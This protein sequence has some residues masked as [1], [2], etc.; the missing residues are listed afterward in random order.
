MRPPKKLIRKPPPGKQLRHLP[1]KS[2]G[3]AAAG[4]PRAAAGWP[5]AAAGWQGAAAGWPVSVG[6]LHSGVLHG[7]D[8]SQDGNVH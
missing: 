1:L 3:W 4:W 7:E 5:G 8:L 2:P 6:S